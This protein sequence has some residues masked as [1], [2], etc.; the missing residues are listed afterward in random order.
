MAVILIFLFF[1]FSFF[2]FLNYQKSTIFNSIIGCILL[3]GVLIVFSSELLSLFKGFNYQYISFFWLLIDLL[4]LFNLFKNRSTFQNSIQKL[5]ILFQSFKTNKIVFIFFLFFILLFVQGIVYPPN[6][7]DSLTYHMGRIPHW[8]DNQSIYPFA[9]HIYRQVY[10]PPL[11]ELIAAH[12]CI[13]NKSDFFANSIQLIYLIGCLATILSIADE[14]KFS[15]R[16]KIIC[17]IFILTTPEILLQATSTQNDIVVSFFILT[18]ILFAVKS[19]HRDSYLNLLLFGICSALAVYTKGTAYIFLLPILIA[20]TI[21]YFKKN[22]NILSVLKIG[23]VGLII[24]FVNSG[25]YYRN[26]S[27]VGDPLGKS[28]EHLFNEHFDIKSTFLTTVKNIGNHF[29]VYPCNDITNQIIEKLHLVLGKKINDP[30]TNFNGLAFKLEKWQ[31]HEDTASNFFQLILIISSIIIILI[32][33]K[34]YPPLALLLISIPIIEFAL[35]CFILKWQPWHTRL[36]TPIFFMCTFFVSMCLDQQIGTHKVN[37]AIFL[38]SIILV[39][40]AF[41]IILFN[42]SRPFVSN[43][44]TKEISMND[45]RFKKYCANFLKYEND[46]K[47]VRYYLKKHKDKVGLELGGDMWEY[48]LYYDI[49]SKKQKIAPQVNIANASSKLQKKKKNNFDYIIS[50]QDTP[51]FTYNSEVFYK[52]KKLKL[53]CFYSKR[54]N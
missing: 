24:L 12:F 6:N 50:F 40:Y 27:F 44:L 46:Y 42:P 39:V 7:W 2:F 54:S 8:I 29:A 33:R 49:Y 3:N 53:F 23:L 36:Q 14:F 28:E 37:R 20:W 43:H 47:T 13:L 22:I 5:T 41:G 26:Y 11:A 18:S 52:I 45:S 4:L 31:H 48:L 51:T 15:K 9:S 32:N 38:P 17:C 10:S 34:K 30:S 16:A 35:F 1:F 19:Y 21:F 25:F